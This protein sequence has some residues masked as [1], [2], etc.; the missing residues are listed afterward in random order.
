MGAHRGRV[1]KPLRTENSCRRVPPIHMLLSVFHVLHTQSGGVDIFKKAHIFL[2]RVLADTIGEAGLQEEVWPLTDR[3][4]ASCLKSAATHTP[5]GVNAVVRL[6]VQFFWPGLIPSQNNRL[7]GLITE[8]LHWT[9]LDSPEYK[10]LYISCPCRCFQ[11]I[12]VNVVK[13]PPFDQRGLANGDLSEDELK[14]L[15]FIYETMELLIH[16]G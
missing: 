8:L 13:P 4:Q 15:S 9:K 10:L 7:T 6:P 14:E 1:L 16:R 2:R 5:C 11:H 3:A 12:N